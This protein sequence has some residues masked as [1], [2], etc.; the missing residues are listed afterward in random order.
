MVKSFVWQ[1]EVLSRAPV[2][3]FNADATDVYGRR[4][5]VVK[6]AQ[7]AAPPELSTDRIRPAG[8]KR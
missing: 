8:Q 1:V 4:T 2:L 5:D 6:R 3:P 7:F